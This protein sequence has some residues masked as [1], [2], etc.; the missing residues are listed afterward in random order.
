MVLRRMAEELGI[1]DRVQW[2]NRIPSDQMPAFYRRLDVLVLPSRSLPNWK[3]Q[4]GRV[5]IEAMSCGVAVIG[6]DSGEIPHVI[7]D[8][9]LIFPEEDVPSLTAHLQRL[10]DDRAAASDLGLAGRARVLAHFTMAQ[11]A[12]ETVAIYYKL[13]GMSH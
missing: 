8:A 13:V 1:A 4:F 10:L 5:L 3:E 6:S 11:I 12:A 9:G 7:G 2:V